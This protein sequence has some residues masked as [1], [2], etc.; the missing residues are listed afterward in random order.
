[1]RS[2]EDR[3]LDM[4]MAVASGEYNLHNNLFNSGDKEEV[5]ERVLLEGQFM[6]E[7]LSNEHREDTRG[8]RARKVASKLYLES[9][10]RTKSGI[11]LI[12]SS[13]FKE[14]KHLGSP[15]EGNILNIG[16]GEQLPRENIY[17]GYRD[18]IHPGSPTSNYPSC[19]STLQQ[20]YSSTRGNINQPPYPPVWG[21]MGS[22]LCYPR[23]GFM[24]E[25]PRNGYCFG[26]YPM[27]SGYGSPSFMMMQRVRG[28]PPYPHIYPYPYPYPN[29]PPQ[30][31]PSP[32][33]H[34]I[35]PN[36]LRFNNNTQS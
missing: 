30:F 35:Y 22:Q 23:G 2:E 10:E 11:N 4:D 34:F 27:D 17:Y 1:M 21:E 33:N 9:I 12:L 25:A 20:H 15:N 14:R 5:V 36:H 6:I 28:M 29:I 8:T 3:G 16:E 13:E 19:P 18:D 26:G 31:P 32:Y 7:I 24:T